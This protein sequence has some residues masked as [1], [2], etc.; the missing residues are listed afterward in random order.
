MTPTAVRDTISSSMSKLGHR[1]GGGTVA[2][3]LRKID[4]ACADAVYGRHPLQ[5]RS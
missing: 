2:M 5:R 1:M 3:R 4:I